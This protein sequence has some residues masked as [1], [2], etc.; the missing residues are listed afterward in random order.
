M[1][2]STKVVEKIRSYQKRMDYARFRQ[3]G[4]F[5]GSGTVESAGKQIAGLR[6][7]RAGARWTEPGAISTAKA[8]AAW[9]SGHW[10]DL[11]SRRTALPLAA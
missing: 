6:L 7:K 1:E 2:F 3:L 8:R 10:D 5:I 4:Y 11:A 9:L